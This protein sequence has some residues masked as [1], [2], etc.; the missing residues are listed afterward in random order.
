VLLESISAQGKA[1]G[2]R[3]SMA[4]AKVWTFDSDTKVIETKPFYF[5]TKKLVDIFNEDILSGR[6]VAKL[7]AA[8][9]HRSGR[10]DLPEYV[11]IIALK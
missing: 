2:T 3:F 1:S 4:I 7:I 10:P 5:D 6:G 9:S 8:T 11:I